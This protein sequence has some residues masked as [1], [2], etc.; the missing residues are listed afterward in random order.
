MKDIRLIS[1]KTIIGELFSD[2][3]ITN[4][5]WVNKAQRHIAR[6]MEI[7]EID[8]YFTRKFQEADV[9]DFKVEL[10]CDLKYLAAVV[11]KDQNYS[12]LPLTRDLALGV[13]FKDINNHPTNR[14]GIDFNYLHTNFEK[15]KIIFLLS[16]LC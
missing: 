6:G 3:N 8:G 9:V 15:G 12:R 4:T 1:S 16:F 11:C 13:V 14:G 7:M 5:D 2:F 10:P